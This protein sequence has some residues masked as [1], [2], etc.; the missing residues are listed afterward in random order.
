MQRGA[1]TF[2]KARRGWGFVGNSWSPDFLLLFIL[3][4]HSS[5]TP[6]YFCLRLRTARDIH[7]R[8]WGSLWYP[9]LQTASPGRAC[10]SPAPHLWVSFS[11]P[12][13]LFVTI[14]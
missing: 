11:E 2:R 6:T 8:F 1:A 3:G 12:V 13:T 14:C 5:P 7:G 9:G 4:L 10:T